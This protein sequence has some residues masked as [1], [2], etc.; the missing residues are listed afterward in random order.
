MKFNRATRSFWKICAGLA[1]CIAVLCSLAP[2]PA[3]GQAASG[4]VRITLDEAI[5][6]AIQHNHNL[7]AARTTI[8]QSQAEEITANLRPNPTLIG[9]WEYLPFFSPSN[10][11]G[12][13]TSPPRPK[14]M[15]GLSYLIERGGKRQDRYQARKTSP[16]R[17]ARWLRTTSA[18]LP[19]RWL[20][21]SST[22]SLP[23]RRS[24]SRSRTSRAFSRPWT[25]AR[26]NSR[27][28]ASA[29]TTT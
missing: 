28:A 17:R 12:I 22:P 15:G 18:G 7:I 20:R 2:L 5:Q 27:P 4:P 26:T 23:N 24:I 8:Q 1:A 19:F 10:L 11:T 9:D 25:S 29:R 21:C 3:F 16:P 14:P 13:P 6:M